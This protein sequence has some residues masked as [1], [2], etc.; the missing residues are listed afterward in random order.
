MGTIL[1][2]KYSLFLY[3]FVNFI[4]YIQYFKIQKEKI[5]SLYQNIN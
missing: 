4:L 2:N 5:F 3:N 1:K